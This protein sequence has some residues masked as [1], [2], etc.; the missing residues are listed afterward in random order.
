MPAVT[1][2]QPK[3]IN[4]RAVL[5][6]VGV[7]VIILLLCLVWRYTL[8][9]APVEELGMEVNLGTSP[10]G[11][12]DDQPE[13]PGD[14]ADATPMSAAAAAASPAEDVS[15]ESLTAEPDA[16]E[17]APP[18]PRTTQRPS[19]RPV[20][21]SRTTRN[22]PENR[23]TN[24]ASTQPQRP[25]YTYPGSNGPGGNGAQSVRTG[26]S[27]GNTTGPGDRGA[28]GGTTG[29]DNYEGSPGRG[30]G[31]VGHT[32]SGRTIIA[33][34]MEAAFREGGRVVVRVTV[35]RSGGIVSHSVERASSAELRRVALEKLGRVRF[36]AKPDAPEEQFGTI[37]FV[38]KTR[39]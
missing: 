13:E 11:S 5:W 4:T 32:L 35:N 14:P 10:D 33:P 29:A 1:A 37:T 26:T 8:P 9:P 30:T 24:A 38:F 12:G 21:E 27:E 20:S 36:T 39:S 18:R 3:S 34:P 16:P 23:A 6:T 28:N 17:V 22:T 19:E 15:V 31:G 25:R 2:Q 7:H